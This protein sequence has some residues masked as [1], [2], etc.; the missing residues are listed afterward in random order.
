MAKID[1]MM[2][3]LWMLSSDKKVTAK[4]ISEKLEIN[5]RTVYRYM[6]TLCASGVPI[7]SDAGHNGG[8]S[9]LNNFVEAPLFFH[10]EEQTALLHAAMLA[11]EAGYFFNGELDKAMS[12]IKMYSNQEQE[13]VIKQHLAGFEVIKPIGKLSV[14]SLLKRLE[15]NIVNKLSVEI[16]YRTGN[17]E[18]SKERLIDP[19]GIVYWNNNWYLIGF[20]HLRNEIRNFRVDR[21]ISTINT[22]NT[23]N[24]PESFSPSKFFMKTL[25]EYKEDK[26]GLMPLIIGGR[27]NALDN[28]CQNWFLAHHIKERNS[29]QVI[30]LL[31]EEVIYKYVPNLIIPYGKSIQ[32]IE[33]LNL[34][35]KMIEALEELIEYYQV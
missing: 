4:E 26:Q 14:E 1:N 17:E 29:N 6:D 2:S 10:T 34:K 32:I 13:K 19:Y 24:P 7:I 9:L 12:K 27:A 28:L 8:Y 31:Q 5:I 15:H 23:F 25:L 11:K 35:E 22:E 3:I 16:K 21:I 33:P 20:C 18:K 30:F